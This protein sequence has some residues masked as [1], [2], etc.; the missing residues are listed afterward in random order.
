MN[1]HEHPEEVPAVLGRNEFVVG[2][3]LVKAFKLKTPL[4]GVIED[5]PR[6]K[7]LAFLNSAGIDYRWE[8]TSCGD[9]NLSQVWFNTSGGWELVF[10]FEADTGRYLGISLEG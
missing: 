4:G 3:Y 6:D 5:T 8:E 2:G 1:E 10:E 9:P 7:L